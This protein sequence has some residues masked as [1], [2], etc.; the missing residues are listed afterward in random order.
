MREP[1]G[2]EEE[3][4]MPPDLVVRDRDPGA[5]EGNVFLGDLPISFTEADIAEEFS[6]YGGKSKAHFYPRLSFTKI[7]P[8]RNFGV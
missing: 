3:F 6:S 1:G 2:A 7:K 5:E 4:Q 8:P